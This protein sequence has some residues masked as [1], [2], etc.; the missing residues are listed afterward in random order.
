MGI[1]QKI[2]G[3]LLGGGIGTVADAADKLISR[4]KASPEETGRLEIRNRELDL[5]EQRLADAGDARQV[6]VNIQQAK[7]DSLFVAGARPFVMWTCG[8]GLAFHLLVTPL[9]QWLILIFG[10]DIPEV[11]QVDTKTLITILGPLLGIGQVLRTVE[12][13]RKVAHG[14]V[15]P[16]NES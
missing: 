3:K 4:F 5:A 14:R 9:A 15:V 12:K 13:V 2:I 6:D 8:I 10:I 16:V 7:H 1:M 11:P